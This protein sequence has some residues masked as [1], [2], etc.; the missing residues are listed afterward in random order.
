MSADAPRLVDLMHLGRPK[1]VGAWLLDRGNIL[2]DP[3]P[4]SCLPTLLPVLEAAPP[5][6]IALT[7]I[8]LDHA[9]ATGTLAARFPEAEVWVH[10]RGAPHMADPQKLLASAQR[11]YGAEMQTLWG[12]FLPVAAER[13]RVL[14]GGEEIEGIRVA[15]TP[16][17][18]AHHVA[19]LH[20]HSGWAFCG[21]VAGVRIDGGPTLAPTPPPDIDLPLWRESIALLEAWRPRA[22]AITHFGVH[23]DVAEQLAQLRSYLGQ[24]EALAARHDVEGFLV[25]V[26]AR[27]AALVPPELASTY[28]QTMPSAQSYSGLRRYLEK[29]G[30]VISA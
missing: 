9:G 20:I 12:E 26:R 29:A 23:H 14:R 24:A 4:A 6:V 25:A 19:Y 7:H 5:R 13:M 10:E 21:D 28:E 11:L 18:A 17:H 1:A 2:V 8:H 27:T 30:R 15:Y 22:L 3:G 16:G